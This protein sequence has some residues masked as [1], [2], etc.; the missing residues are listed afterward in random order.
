MDYAEMK[1]LIGLSTTR[2]V[3][4]PVPGNDRETVKYSLYDGQNNLLFVAIGRHG[5]VFVPE[6]QRGFWS[7]VS[8]KGDKLQVNWAEFSDLFGMLG[9]KYDVQQRNL[10]KGMER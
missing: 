10:R 5:N 8:A 4:T 2:V 7:L 1:N 9:I 6:N 3:K